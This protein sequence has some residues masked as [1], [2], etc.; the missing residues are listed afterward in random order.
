MPATDPAVVSREQFTVAG[1]IRRL[2]RQ[3][4]GDE[5]LVAGDERRTWSEEYQCACRVAQACERDGVAIGDRLAV[6]D[7]NGMA[8]FDV[9]FGGALLGAVNVAV[10]WRLAP[11][12]M[13]AIIDDSAA[14]LL[15]V[16][17][18]YLP[19]LAEAGSA[20]PAV[21]RIVVLSDQLGGDWSCPDPR[22][23]S[24][25]RWIES[26]DATDPGHVGG[27]E[28]VSMQ[29]YTSGTTGLPKGVM[30]T[31]ANISTAVSEAGTTF[32]I[33]ED[34]VSLVAMPLFHIGGSGWALCAMSRGG[35]SVILRDVDPT[36]LLTLVERERISEMFLVPAVLMFLLATPALATTDLSTLRRI[37]YGASPISEDVL[38]RCMATFGCDFVQVY[39][40]T[41]TTGAIT[42][43]RAEDHDPDGPRRGL[44]RSAGRPHD[45]VEI[46][47]VDPDSGLDATLGDV[48]EIWTRSAYN[49]SGYWGKPEETAA[50]IDAE[51]WLRTGDA[52]YFDAA[53]YLYLHDR[54][55]DMIV[56]GGENIYP[57][58]VENV[59]LSHASVADAAVIG[60]PDERW[61]ET[62]KALVVLAPGATLDQAA[63]IA[64]CRGD[65]ASYKCPTSVEA[66]EALPRNPSGKILK[67]ELRAP[68][69]AGRE[70]HIN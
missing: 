21:R 37:F 49:M 38:V 12:E 3:R 50:T 64:H 2:A 52:G 25:D 45:G 55:K 20:L 47:V 22:A 28:E 8:Y 30:L 6:L 23:V 46:R 33:A 60:V 14:R 19:A 1:L 24:F 51:G 27:P 4:P 54:M 48:G 26:C 63:I 31:N 36:R 61:G 17:T 10:N 15:F 42:A 66:I 53:G 70:R 40:M 5:M 43:L 62:V 34:T 18:D 44:L 67:R 11:V 58:E 32:H 7:R 57:A 29:L 16:H 59:L 13:G 65:L 68:Y 69:W 41:E 56:S 35:R 39:G 9:L